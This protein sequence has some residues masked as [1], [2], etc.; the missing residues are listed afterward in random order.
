MKELSVKQAYSAW[1]ALWTTASLDFSKLI[2]DNQWQFNWLI[3]S[4]D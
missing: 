1:H 4:I 2:K 3:V